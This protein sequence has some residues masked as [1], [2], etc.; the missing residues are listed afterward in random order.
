MPHLP[1]EYGD[2]GG[3]VARSYVAMEPNG[4]CQTHDAPV[5]SDA[6]LACG[7]SNRKPIIVNRQSTPKNKEKH[8]GGKFKLG[9]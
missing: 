4:T 2:I 5:H 8:L 3:E 9:N 1:C 6:R 7:D